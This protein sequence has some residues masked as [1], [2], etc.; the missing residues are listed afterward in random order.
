MPTVRNARSLVTSRELPS[1]LQISGKSPVEC[2]VLCGYNEPSLPGKENPRKHGSPDF[3]LILHHVYAI[4]R[5]YSLHHVYIV[6]NVSTLHHVDTL[7]QVT[8][9]PYL[10][11]IYYVQYHTHK[12]IFI[13]FKSTYLLQYVV[14]RYVSVGYRL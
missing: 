6:H 2:I 13:T 5:V 7:H 1:G 14:I 12:L 3:I 11:T 8:T 9:I 10:C 4:H